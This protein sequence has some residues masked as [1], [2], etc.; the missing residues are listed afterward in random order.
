M[1]DLE[2][3][4]YHAYRSVTA[5]GEMPQ[6]VQDV[7]RVFWQGRSI[8][9]G[10]VQLVDPVCDRC[11]RRER[12]RRLVLLLA[13]VAV[14]AAVSGLLW[15]W[16]LRYRAQFIEARD[17]L[18]Q[19]DPNLHPEQLPRELSRVEKERLRSRM[20]LREQGELQR[21][22]D[23]ALLR[24]V[25]LRWGATAAAAAAMLLVGW[26]A[27]ELRGVN[28]GRRVAV[29][30]ARPVLRKQGLKHVR[31]GHLVRGGTNGE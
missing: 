31:R 27:W 11:V 14:L 25:P 21:A 13:G 20:Y 15:E 2:L 30:A 4:D 17:D 9:H 23:A 29:A 24:A 19:L 28:L 26:G 10:L 22:K 6:R 7:A 5:H 8:Y 12:W 1:D 18:D 3:Y 16:H